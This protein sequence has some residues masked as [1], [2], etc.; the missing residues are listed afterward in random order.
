[1][2]KTRHEPPAKGAMTRLAE[3]LFWLR[4]EL[5][6]RLNHINLYALDGKDGWILLDCG[7]NNPETA[8]HWQALLEGPLSGRPVERI[9]VSHHHV[10]HVGYAGPLAAATGAP[11]A[12]TEPEHAFTLHMLE[13]AGPEFGALLEGA[14]R[15]YG[16]GD[17]VLAMARQD[18]HRFSRHVAP[19]PGAGMLD[20]GDTVTTKGGEWRVRVDNGHSM[21]QIGLVDDNR[22][23]YLAGDFLLPRISPN[24][25]ARLDDPDGDRLGAYLEYLDG[26]RTMPD[27]WLVLPGHDWPFTHGGDR[28][29]ALVAHHHHRLDTLEKAAAAKPISTADAIEA[30]FDRVFGAHEVFF[31][32][33]EARA[34]LTHLAATG[35]VAMDEKDGVT[36]F[37]AA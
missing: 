9:I 27:D 23:L 6:F 4:F 18:H 22:G 5:P 34:H 10:D 20:A 3:D 14:Y 11:I 37:R 21:A 8:E 1:M 17:E 30:L 35:R 25:P 29:K 13:T 31:A 33:G 12:M 26:A 2:R 24:I 36:L 32:A 15:R 7:V 16:L 19:L 28:A